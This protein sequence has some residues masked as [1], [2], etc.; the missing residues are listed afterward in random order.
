VN[1]ANIRT[2]IKETSGPVPC[3]HMMPSLQD[4]EYSDYEYDVTTD[5]GMTDYTVPTKL[6][7]DY[8]ADDYIDF[9]NENPTTYH[10][11][12]YFRDLLESNGFKHISESCPLSDSKR[13]EI[14]HQG[15]LFYTIR[16]NLSIVA[17]VIGGQWQ[18]KSGLGVIGSHVDA[19][20][21]KL[22]PFS[23]VS[24]VA[25]YQLLGVAPYSGTLNKL[26][27]DRDL[28]IGGKVLIKNPKTDRISSKL[29]RSEFPVAKIPSLAEHFVDF[30]KQIYDKETKM[31]PII[32]ISDI[33][34]NSATDDERASPLFQKHSIHLLRLVLDLTSTPVKD[35]V[36][37]DLELYDSQLATRGGL[38]NE[39][40]FAPRVDDRLCSYASV[41]S[42]IQ[43]AKTIN[44][45]K[46]SGC[47]VVY[48]VDHEEI[49]S[50]SRTG[51]KGQFLNSVLERILFAHGTSAAKEDFRVTFANSLILSADVTH[52]LNPNFA[53]AYLKDHAPLPNI[54]LT[55]K[56]NSN[57]KNM[58]DSVGI[59]VMRRIAE[60][61]GLKLQLF[62]IKNGQ[63]SGGTI[64]PMISSN[65]GARVVD[66]G[67]SQLSMHSIRA[68]FGYKEVGIGIDTFAAFFKDWMIV[69]GEYSA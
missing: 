26:W 32:G 65:T 35:L 36:G 2:A 54:G 44:I 69:Y 13:D 47:L 50:A 62:H 9:T 45:A 29:V 67:L 27:L 49:G 21:V 51:V 57:F 60:N 42:L 56:Q 19:L 14:G 5:D 46:T 40:I 3:Q 30:E 17:F 52:A 10:A 55:I 58:T 39:F 25:N 11:V 15:G 7:H 37:L 28:A 18:P 16:S 34:D 31:V 53:D 8:Y 23:R 59:D 64:G 12:S 66:V 33:D 20:T 43:Y 6:L 48:L 61:N 38:S 68:M 41:Y 22:K 63:P 1:G 24:D 4:F